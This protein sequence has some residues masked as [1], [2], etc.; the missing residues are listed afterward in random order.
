[1][2]KQWVSDLP[3]VFDMQAR[4]VVDH[5]HFKSHKGKYCATNTNPGTHKELKGGANLSI[6]EQRFKYV[7]RH[8]RSFRYMNEA[9]FRFMLAMIVRLDHKARRDGFL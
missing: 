8:K 9:R 3:S 4:M 2:D 7:A 6:C 1:M 5:F